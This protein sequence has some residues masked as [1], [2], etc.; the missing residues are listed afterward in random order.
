MWRIIFAGSQ[1]PWH[2]G[3]RLEADCQR[4]DSLAIGI[5]QISRYDKAPPEASQ[6]QTRL[7]RYSPQVVVCEGSCVP[8]SAPL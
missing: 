6:P 3:G 5:E 7:R 8:F 1:A 2:L 4:F